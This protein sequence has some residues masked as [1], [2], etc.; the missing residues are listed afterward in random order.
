MSRSLQC[1]ARTNATKKN[2]QKWR[3]QEYC[4]RSFQNRCMY[5]GKAAKVATMH[6]PDVFMVHE[7]WPLNFRCRLS[8]FEFWES[9]RRLFLRKSFESGQNLL[10]S[11]FWKLF[12]KTLRQG[13][14]NESYE[15]SSPALTRRAHCSYSRLSSSITLVLLVPTNYGGNC[16]VHKSKLLMYFIIMG[17][18]YC[19]YWAWCGPGHDSR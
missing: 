9:L 19:P 4:F 10:V 7:S 12:L 8:I 18:R 6:N 3:C 11:G 14:S 16:A 2:F 17:W 13:K 5:I 15:G 1:F